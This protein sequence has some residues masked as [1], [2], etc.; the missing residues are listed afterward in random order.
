M[1]T[2]PIDP[3]DS[4]YGPRLGGT[5]RHEDYKHDKCKCKHIFCA[6]IVDHYLENVES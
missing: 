3:R 4:Q 5:T 2:S 1:P 6:E